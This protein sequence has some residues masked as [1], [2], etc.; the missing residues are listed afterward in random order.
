[1]ARK[2]KITRKEMLKRPDEFLTLS[3]QV[4]SWVK[5]NYPMAI[6][7]GSGVVLLL[8]LFFGYSAYQNRQ[9]KQAHEKYFTI[10][11]ST[12]SN[13]RIKQLEALVKDYPRTK[14]AYA[15]WVTLGQLYYQKKDF[16]RAAWAYRSALNQGK[17]PSSFKVLILEDLAYA[18]EEQ[19]DLQQ[20]AKIFA[21]LSREKENLLKEDIFLS[22]ARVYQKM[23]KSQEAKATY[24]NFLQS[25]PKSTFAPMVKDRLGRL[26]G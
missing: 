1:M 2:K 16:P 3:T 15:S 6:W 4:L 26:N 14:A 13:Q 19:G 7:L 12:D 10:Q 8:I 11:E 22:L 20:A 25:F 23:G 9:E 24:Q 5:E 21:E 18:Y 17:F